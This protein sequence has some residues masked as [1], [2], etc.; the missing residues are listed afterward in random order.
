M[1]R[2]AMFEKFL[3]ALAIDGR[4]TISYRY[5]RIISALNSH[6]RDTDSKTSNAL[7]VGSYGRGTGIHGLSDLDMIYKMPLGLWDDYKG[8]GQARVLQRV[9]GAIDGTYPKTQSNVDRLV[10][11]VSFEKYKI[12]VQPC[13]EQSD[14]SFL[15][16]DTYKKRWLNTNPRDEMAA[17]SVQND[18]K[19]GNVKDLCKMVRAWRNHHG[20]EMGGLL[21]DTLVYQFFQNT[22][23]Y[24]ATGYASHHEMSTDFFKYLSEEPRDKS[25]YRA[26]GSSQTVKIKKAFQKSAKKAYELCLLAT[27]AQGQKNCNDK[28]RKVFGRSFPAAAT[29]EQLSQASIQFDNTEEFIEDQFPVDVRHNLDIDADVR[30]D[31]YRVASLR[32]MIASGDRLKAKKHLDFKVVASDVPEPFDVKWKVLNRGEEARRRRP[33]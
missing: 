11:V 10:V 14:G 31:G 15:Y 26:P 1:T 17:I 2:A 30:Q 22:A 7:Q 27:E 29:V 16:P 13:F 20:R 9:K 4:E 18:G 24:D 21:I 12:E 25:N 23:K 32:E 3:E 6:F 5:G 33:G 8:E 19:H 28:W